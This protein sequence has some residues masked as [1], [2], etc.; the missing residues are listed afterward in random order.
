M[1][2]QT[3]QYYKI[4]MEQIPKDSTVLDLGCGCGYPFYDT[5]F[6]LLVGIDIFRKKF[7]MIE[8]TVILYSDIRNI[9][10]MIY[11]KQFD[12]V[13]VI[14]VIEHLSKEEGYKLIKD[15]EAIARNK[16]MIFTPTI[17]SENNVAVEDKNCWAYGNKHNYHKSLWKEEDFTK[18]GY[19]I[20]PCQPGYVLA[21]KEPSEVKENG[22]KE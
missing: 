11:E 10:W 19:E 6:P 22:R 3:N 16:V 4:M 21:I 2:V 14:D 15:M 12:V 20:V 7:D 1:H 17:W 13:T 8:Y 18:R 9:G 5:C